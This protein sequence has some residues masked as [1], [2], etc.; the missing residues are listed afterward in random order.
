METQVLSMSSLLLS[1]RALC[2]MGEASEKQVNHLLWLIAK[3]KPQ[4]QSLSQPNLPPHLS[5][6]VEK[7]LLLSLPSSDTVH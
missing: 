4:D 7:A 5:N 1:L 2:A 6:L 3:A